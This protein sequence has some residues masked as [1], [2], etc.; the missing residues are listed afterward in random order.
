MIFPAPLLPGDGIAIVATAKKLPD[1]LQAAT[2]ILKSWHLNVKVHPNTF[3]TSGYFAGTDAERL[4]AFQEVLDDPETKAILFARGGYGTTRI[5][6]LLDWTAFLQQ[7]KWLI[8]F[9]DLTS[10]LLQLNQLNIAA[11]HGAMAFTLPWH[12]SSQQSL[13]NLLFGSKRSNFQLQANALNQSGLVEGRITGGNL[14]LILESIGTK[15]EI[16]TDGQIL[17]IEEVGEATYS[18]DRMLNQLKRMGKL[19]H[20]VGVLVGDISQGSEEE[21]SFNIPALEVIHSYFRPLGIPMAFGLPIGH[22]KENQAIML[23]CPCVVNI[24]SREVEINYQ[25]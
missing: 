23:N 9:S 18:I 5:I 24:S 4:R 1:D 8:G 11:I 16:Q 2:E 19:N 22:E 14:S 13:K 3:L 12:T 10:V 6:D 17:L 21:D 7:P 15:Q 25:A 20:I